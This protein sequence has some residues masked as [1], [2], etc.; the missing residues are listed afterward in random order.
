MKD[1][2]NAGVSLSCKTSYY[3]R[4]RLLLFMLTA[5]LVLCA[6]RK[7]E[8]LPDNV[9]VDMQTSATSTP[10][11]TPSPSPTP[12]PIIDMPKD[13]Y[14]ASKTPRS[15][16]DETEP[17]IRSF[18][19]EVLTL[20]P[21]YAERASAKIR[22]LTQALLFKTDDEQNILAG[23]DQP[24]VAYECAVMDKD[25]DSSITSLFGI[26]DKDVIN[27][28][29]VFRVVLKKGI[30]FA[31]G[32]PVTAKDVLFSLETLTNSD[33][34][35][36]FNLYDQDIYGLKSFREQIP[37][38]RYRIAKAA[39]EAGINPDGSINSSPDA[40]TRELEDFWSYFDEAGISFAQDIIDYVNEHYGQNAYVQPFLSNSLTY[41]KVAADENLK[42]AYAFAI[43]GYLK[44][45]DNST[46]IMTDVIGNTYDLNNTSLT[47][48]E[49]F[50]AIFEYYGYDLDD[51]TGINYECPYGDKPFEKYVEEAYFKA[52]GA[53][54]QI[55]GVTSGVYKYPDGAERECVY[56][57][58][59]NE[60][61]LEDIN[62]FVSPQSVYSGH[63][64]ENILTGAG[65]Y[66]L[67]SVD[68]AAGIVHLIANDSYM[69]GS[70]VKKHI[71]FVINNQ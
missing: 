41:A 6:C 58:V 61:P 69:L 31:D 28:Y 33:Y 49:L 16:S 12:T 2:K 29:K 46:G 47:A 68:E 1:K 30:T 7:D 53:V 64:R 10:T 43:W 23:I 66:E 62:F 25:S 63:E 40:T 34:N 11:P 71:D 8:K 60:Q 19:D 5:V 15:A 32:S 27:N 17:E 18:S 24:T 56:F 3:G 42:V 14:D 39:L 44:S 67:E 65:E 35:G 55:A 20:N 54:D 57:L 70:P 21:F 9:L 45:Y 36:P 38:D 4:L 22:D 13:R 48:A 59:G 51:Q 50:N 52:S 37:M 26:T